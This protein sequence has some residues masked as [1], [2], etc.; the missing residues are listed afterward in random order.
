MIDPSSSFLNVYK[1]VER[2]LYTKVASVQS[3]LLL[4]QD[5]ITTRL[6]ELESAKKGVVWRIGQGAAGNTGSLNIF[7]GATT[8]VDPGHLIQ[9]GLFDQIKAAF[10]QAASIEV[11]DYLNNSLQTKVNELAF[12]GK[13]MLWPVMNEPNG[14]TTRLLSAKVLFAQKRS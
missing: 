9:L 2:F 11:F 12:V 3:T 1:S 5:D 6:Q 10:D 13:V 7:A 8:I 14:F 4:N